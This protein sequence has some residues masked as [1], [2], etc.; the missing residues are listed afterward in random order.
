MQ[1]LSEQI[2]G[3]LKWDE[4]RSINVLHHVV[5]QDGAS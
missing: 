5:K 1:R 2:D 4:T 3:R